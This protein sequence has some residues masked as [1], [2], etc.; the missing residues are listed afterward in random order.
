MG[1]LEKPRFPLPQ[2]YWEQGNKPNYY[3]T[4]VTQF[5]NY[6]F[7]LNLDRTD[8]QQLNKEYK[9]R[10]LYSLLGAEGTLRFANQ[11]LAHHLPKTDHAVF[12]KAI[13]DFFAEP[14]NELHAEFDFQ[15]H[16]Q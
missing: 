14:V 13:S 8:D 16:L 5:E 4:W 7:W 15:N 2:R 3:R 10:L 11:P 6:V 9:N 1:E 12:T